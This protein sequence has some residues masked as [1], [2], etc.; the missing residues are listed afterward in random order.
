MDIYEIRKLLGMS[1]KHDR[2]YVG[3]YVT[4]KFEVLHDYGAGL[5]RVSIYSIAESKNNFVVGLSISTIDDG[6]WQASEV[7][8]TYTMEESIKR[9][10][11]IANAFIDFMDGG[12]VLPSEEVLNNFLMTQSMWGEYTG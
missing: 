2:Q 6:C 11:E 7:D 9:V 10:E 4:G 8:T 1:K 12:N 3:T 5:L